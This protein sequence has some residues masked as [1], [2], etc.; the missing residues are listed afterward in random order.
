MNNDSFENFLDSVKEKFAIGIM[1]LLALFTTINA[2]IVTFEQDYNGFVIA[3]IVVAITLVV[4]SGY[5]IYILRRRRRAYRR[6]TKESVLRVIRREGY[7]PK[8]D[9]EGDI[10]FEV[11]DATYMAWFDTSR[12]ALTYGF[13]LSG[14]EQQIW[15]VVARVNQ[16]MSMVKIFAYTNEAERGT[17]LI[18]IV[19]DNICYYESEL[20]DRFSL[21]LSILQAA[22]SCFAQEWSSE[23]NNFM[24]SERRDHIYYP[25]FRWLPTLLEEVRLG[26]LQ[27]GALTDEEFLRSTIQDHIADADAIKEWNSFKIYRVDNIYVYKLIIYKF[28]E[29]KIVPEAQYG[30]V[31]MNTKTYKIDYYTLEMTFNDRWVYGKM[32]PECHS[33]YGEVDTPDLD[34]FIEWIFTKDKQIVARYNYT[35]VSNCAN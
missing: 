33:N 16:K 10:G 17:L 29:P 7:Y 24:K 28:P 32:T 20:R 12:F 21:Y 6:I 19:F 18:Q 11:G 23:Q 13:R 4:A 8:V 31:L 30:A 14:N 3:F 9:S 27:S 22:V 2:A 35:D 5:I 15:D 34:K 25:E 1:V 26:N